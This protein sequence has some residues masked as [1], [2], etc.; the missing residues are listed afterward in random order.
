M[1]TT[2]DA[3]LFLVP[4]LGMLFVSIFAVV[5]WQWAAGVELKW[6]WAGAALWA[7]GVTLKVP[8]SLLAN[9][10]V[11]GFLESALP[12]SLFS[13]GAGLYL[14]AVSATFELGVTWLAARRWRGFGC[15]A[16]RAVAVGVGAGAIEALLL[17]LINVVAGFA[18]AT[19]GLDTEDLRYMQVGAAETPMF[20]LAQPTERII[21]LLGHTSTRALV[22][23]GVPARRPWMLVFGFAVFTFIDGIAATF[24]LWGGEGSARW[25]LELAVLPFTLAAV[26]SLLFS[27]RGLSMTD[28]RIAG[29]SRQ[30]PHD[31]FA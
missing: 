30:A 17:G 16:G 22:L 2:F 21:A 24:P 13:H 4:G 3:L 12:H 25:W 6:F 15:D 8:F 29:C 19:G 26:A 10:S 7:A 14:G 31:D 23:L 18:A 5:V 9:H 28:R 1:D 11:V 27:L 20:W